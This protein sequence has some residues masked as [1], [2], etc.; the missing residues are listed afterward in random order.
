MTE[1]EDDT[2]S[3]LIVKRRDYGLAIRT[4]N[5]SM[6]KHVIGLQSTLQRT[7]QTSLCIKFP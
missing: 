7:I 5:V 1:R 3:G 2:H 4:C 6:A